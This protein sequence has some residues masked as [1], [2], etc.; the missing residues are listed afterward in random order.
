MTDTF[1]P[2]GLE[3]VPLEAAE[4]AAALESL[5]EPAERAARSIEQAFDRAGESLAA[6]LS[7]AAAD[8][9]ITLAELARAVLAAANSAVGTLMGGG[10]AGL[11]E[12]LASAV[13]GLFSGARA[14]G[15]PV[16]SGGAYLVGERGP[17]VFQPSQAGVVG[18]VQGSGM[19][20]NLKVE[21]GASGLLR[22]ETQ[23]AQALARAVALGARRY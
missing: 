14:D 17:E 16:M 8:G 6:S 2:S 9:E 19:V 15:G 1:G 18:G 4:A 10:G 23:I 11:G 21:G 12:A 22:S 5:K 13:G 7:R 20:L 3:T